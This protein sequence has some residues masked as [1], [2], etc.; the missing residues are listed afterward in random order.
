MFSNKPTG[1][2]TASAS[3]EKGHEELKLIMQTV[4]AKLTPDTALLIRG[5]K[6]KVN[7]Q[8]DIIDSRQDSLRMEEV[9]YISL[10]IRNAITQ[11]AH[12][13]K[14]NNDAYT[15]FHAL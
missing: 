3:G 1:V 9:H 5:I 14:K 8:G 13:S 15:F 10:C 2:I 11:T 6:G 7:E 12:N 4:M